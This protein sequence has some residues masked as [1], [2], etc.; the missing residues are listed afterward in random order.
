MSLCNKEIQQKKSVRDKIASLAEAG[1]KQE[2][3]TDFKDE[4]YFGF[5][6]RE[7][8]TLYGHWVSDPAK[9]PNSK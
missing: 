1:L 8:S 9:F 4:S 2:T 6:A 7:D 5:W 3:R